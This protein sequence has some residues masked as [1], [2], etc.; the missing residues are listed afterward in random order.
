M[1]KNLILFVFLISLTHISFAQ[2]TDAKR[3]EM[4]LQYAKAM[5][6]ANNGFLGEESQME[7]VLEDAHGT[8]VVREM[9]GK[10]LERIS[11]GDK[12]IMEFLKPGDVKGTKMLTWSQKSGDDDQWLYL[13][14]TR[15]PKRIT[16]TG[17]NASFMASE[18]S[19]EDLSSQEVEKFNFKYLKDTKS[20]FGDAVIIE[21]IPKET[22]GYSKQILTIVKKINNPIT[23]EYYD[24]KGELLKIATFENYKSFKVGSK[25]IYR[26]SSIS[27]KNVQTKKKSTFSWKSRKLGVKLNESEFSQES[28]R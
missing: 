27:M 15:R 20:A 5:E 13:P 17:K 14:S 12:S 7:M 2:L 25:E 24:R 26:A 19:F 1:F 10:I 11:Q 18:F 16:G 28:L 8:K 23:I 6:A 9:L 21:R 4:G 3:M 22:S